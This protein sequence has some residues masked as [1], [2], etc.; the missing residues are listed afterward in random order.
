M[1][2][3]TKENMSDITLMNGDC[4]E[5]MKTIPNNSI[6]LVLTDPP[7]GTTRCTWDT[8]IEF[9]PMWKE[10]IRVTK[11]NAAMCIFGTEPFSSLLRISNIRMFRYDWAWEKTHVTGFLNAK[12]IKVNSINHV[13]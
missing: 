12:K 6:D 8:I 10:L 2:L 4:L 1:L 9:E 5:L 3:T 7:Y 13:N 11:P